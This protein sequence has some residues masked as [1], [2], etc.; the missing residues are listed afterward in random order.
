[1]TPTLKSQAFWEHSGGTS[2]EVCGQDG[3]GYIF[4]AE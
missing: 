2:E 1:M 3:Q 4:L